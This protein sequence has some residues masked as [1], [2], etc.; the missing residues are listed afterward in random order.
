VWERDRVTRLGAFALLILAAGVALVTL[1]CGMKAPT[2]PEQ[3]QQRDSSSVTP[4]TLPP[5]APGKA[6]TPAP[7]PG[8]PSPSP[9][10]STSPSPDA[11]GC[12]DPLP[13]PISEITVKVHMKGS[14]AWTLDS[15]PL[16]VDHAYC[17]KIGFTDGRSFCPVRPE[18]HPERA[19]CELY[20]VGRALDTN[21]PGPTWYFKDAFCTGKA[22]GCLN[23]PDNQ[24]QLK[25]YVSGTF[26]ACARNGVCG[27]VL[28][29]R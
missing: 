20:A 8:D 1:A 9:S 16:V 22:S 11:S 26:K 14:D 19:A 13:P 21:R 3:E 27:E 7:S 10:P 29:D 12:G 28:A 15:T 18:G 25:I 4:G 23:S 17:A 2:P 6:P 5:A 24:Y